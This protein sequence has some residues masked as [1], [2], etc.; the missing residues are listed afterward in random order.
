[1]GHRSLRPRLP[2]RPCGPWHPAHGKRAKVVY[3]TNMSRLDRDKD[4][5]ACE[6]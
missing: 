6:A 2:A 1:M 4:G 3:R 5:T